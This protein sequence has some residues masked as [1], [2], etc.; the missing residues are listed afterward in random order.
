MLTRNVYLRLGFSTFLVGLATLGFTDALGWVAL[1][2]T[3]LVA[4]TLSGF[5]AVAERTTAVAFSHVGKKKK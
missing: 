3:C 4:R 1:A 5:R 2:G